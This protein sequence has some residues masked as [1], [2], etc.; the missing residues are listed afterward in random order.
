MDEEDNLLPENEG[1]A[2]LRTRRMDERCVILRDQFKATFYEY[3]K[4]YKGHAFLKSWE[5]KEAGG[6]GQLPKLWI[7]AI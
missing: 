5:M 7:K 1:A 2:W 4:Y 3:V 6:V